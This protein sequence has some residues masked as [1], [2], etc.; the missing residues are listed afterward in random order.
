MKKLAILSVI[1]SA[2]ILSACTDSKYVIHDPNMPEE[3]IQQYEDKISD[4]LEKYNNS[5]T[6]D[7]KADYAEEVAFSYMSL[8]NYKE[9]IEYYEEILEYD[10]VHF[11]ALSNIAYM[12]EEVGEYLT[13]LEFQQRLYEANS[14]NKEVVKDTI[15]ILLASGKSSDALSVLEKFAVTEAG[16]NDPAFVSEQFELIN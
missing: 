3:Y 6:E 9:S 12:H 16:K 10:S 5:T 8:G 4:N 2:L 15:R 7:E 13:A 11:P 1:I 14:T